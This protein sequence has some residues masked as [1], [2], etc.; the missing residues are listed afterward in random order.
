MSRGNPAGT[1]PSIRGLSRGLSRH[2]LTTRV[3][4]LEN[5]DTVVRGG[6]H[7]HVPAALVGQRDGGA[8]AGFAGLDAPDSRRPSM[9]LEH[10]DEHALVAASA[11]PGAP[12][13]ALRRLADLV[14]RE[15]VV[16]GGRVGPREVHGVVVAP[17]A[18]VGT[19]DSAWRRSSSPMNG[20]AAIESY[21][22]AQRT[23]TG[24]SASVLS[25]NLPHA[26][27]VFRLGQTAAN[28][29]SQVQEAKGVGG[30][31]AVSF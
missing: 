9:R 30:R 25:V 11:C 31:R 26:R 15:R 2:V 27:V 5:V 19:Q 8:A 12:R 1:A 22:I 20:A 23:A 14:D 28:R 16:R 3:E 29:R 7:E 13:V 24:P 4:A 10:G 6:H 21:A 18:R 17:G